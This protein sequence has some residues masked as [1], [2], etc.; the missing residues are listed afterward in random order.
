LI[1][2]WK[3]PEPFLGHGEPKD[4]IRSS[5]EGMRRSQFALVNRYLTNNPYL[6][7]G[8]YPFFARG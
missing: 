8:K 3:S 7:I 1:S 2:I 5:Y 6:R 4:G